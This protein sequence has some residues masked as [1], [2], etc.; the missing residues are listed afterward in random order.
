MHF[1]DSDDNGWPMMVVMALVH[2]GDR[3]LPSDGILSGTGGAGGAGG[4]CTVT[5]A[6]G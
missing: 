5:M 3:M 2:S 1:P 4:V 6:R